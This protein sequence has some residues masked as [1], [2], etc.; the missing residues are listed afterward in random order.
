MIKE[1]IMI[2]ITLGTQSC[3]FTRCLKM[4]EELLKAV[5]IQEPIIAQTGHTKYKPIGVQCLDFVTEEEYQKY[6]NDASVV[7]SHAGTGALFSSINKGKKVIAVA[8]LQKF[9]EMI[10]NHQTEI[11]KKLNTEGHIIDGTDSILEAWKKLK[12]FT[13]KPCNFKNNI[14]EEIEKCI[15]FWI[16]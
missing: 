2:F 6:I 14:V 15:D 5:D 11:V 7:I 12:D 4:V 8:R 9:G 10:D 3:D 13:P 1:N 16:K